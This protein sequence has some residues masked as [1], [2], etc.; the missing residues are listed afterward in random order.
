MVTPVKLITLMTDFGVSSP[1]IAAM[2]GVILS[3]C[4]EVQIVDLTHVIPPQDIRQGALAWEQFTPYFPTG[5]VHVGVV[6]PGVGSERQI[7]LAEIGEFFYLGPDNGLFTKVA[8][9]QK[10]AKLYTINNRQ[11]WRDEVSRTFHGRDIMAPVAAHLC[12]GVTSDCFGSE[13]EVWQ[14]LDWPE[15]HMTN[16]SIE[17]TIASIDSFGNL[18]TD[19]TAEMLADVPRGEETVVHCDGHETFGIFETY[20]DQPELTLVAIVGSSGFLEIALVNENAS[21]MLGVKVG[22]PV[23]VKW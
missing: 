1:Y 5:S 3:I 9:N 12:S 7:L 8:L 6:D 17:G 4:P 10:P 20:A 19:I 23:K 13:Q 14:T 21:M 15:V 16:R 18:V 22:Q 2:K 11:Y